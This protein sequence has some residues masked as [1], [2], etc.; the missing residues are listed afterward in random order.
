PTCGGFVRSLG[1]TK[2][3]LVETHLTTLTE[4]RI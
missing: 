2:L 1:V 3:M 4:L